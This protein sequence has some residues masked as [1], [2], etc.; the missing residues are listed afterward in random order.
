MIV[1]AHQPAYL[2][3]PGYF[4]KIARADAF[5]ILD[6]VQYERNS[7][8]NRNLIAVSGKPHWLTIP[9]HVE[10][11]LRNTIRGT[12][13]DN[14]QNWRMKHWETIRHNYCKASYW[15]EVNDLVREMIYEPQYM[16]DEVWRGVRLLP[17]KTQ[18]VR[19]SSIGIGGEK[20]EL[21]I[22][23]CKHFHADAFLFGR[24]GR[25][26]VD[27]EYFRREGIEPLF[28]EYTYPVYG[29]F[30]NEFLPGLSIVDMLF[31]CGRKATSEM[32]CAK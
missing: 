7:F 20:Q 11:H 31:H 24:N 21:I 25:D 3:W 5:V 29:Q 6:D 32:V 16:L 13:I 26:Y 19:Q 9:V 1:S 14:A 22:N 30:G 2:P 17:M 27:V 15:G 12:W 23:L 8:I 10:G 28:Q 4:Q 18:I